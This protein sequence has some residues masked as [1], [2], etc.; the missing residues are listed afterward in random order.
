MENK[1][2]LDFQPGIFALLARE[3][4]T[5]LDEGKSIS[6]KDTMNMCHDN[7]IIGWLEKNTPR[8]MSFWDDETKTIMSVEFESL[9]NCILPEELG[10]SNNG[11]SL[12]LS[13]CL[14]FIMTPPTRT[15]EDCM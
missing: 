2:W 5:L 6:V 9:A 11:I 7:T 14:V 4:N 8:S 1:R 10:V 12:L 3:L 13:F 15:I